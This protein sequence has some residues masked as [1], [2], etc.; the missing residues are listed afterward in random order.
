[1][2]GRCFGF[3]ISGFGSGFK[4]PSGACAGEASVGVCAGR[5]LV[6]VVLVVGALVVITPEAIAIPPAPRKE[7]TVLRKAF[8]S[9][10]AAFRERGGGVFP[11]LGLLTESDET[12]RKGLGSGSTTRLGLLFEGNSKTIQEG[13]TVLCS[14]FGTSSLMHNQLLSF[15]TTCATHPYVG[16]GNFSAPTHKPPELEVLI[17]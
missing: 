12:F 1:L 14:G 10:L 3:Q 6:A 17:G 7:S 13:H 2:W 11:F 8:I 4:A 15:A 5:V 16:G 9:G